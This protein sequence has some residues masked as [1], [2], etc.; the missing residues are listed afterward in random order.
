MP[1]DITY[2]QIISCVNTSLT[3]QII[4]KSFIEKGKLILI[5]DD[6]Q[7]III[8][9]KNIYTSENEN[10]ICE[11]IAIAKEKGCN[12]PD[13]SVKHYAKEEGNEYVLVRW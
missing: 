5:L 3:C 7:K 4:K 9:G 1:D 2:I 8:S 10:R 12:I 13:K 11:L 6:Y